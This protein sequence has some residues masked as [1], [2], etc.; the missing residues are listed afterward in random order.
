MR[1]G[2]FGAQSWSRSISSFS[3]RNYTKFTKILKKN[4]VL[5][6]TA[7]VNPN[8]TYLRGIL[9]EN[10]EKCWSNHFAIITLAVFINFKCRTLPLMIGWDGISRLRIC[11]FRAQRRSLACALVPIQILQNLWKRFSDPPNLK[12]ICAII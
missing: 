10:D 5:W 6:S 1:F 4:Q 8:L 3:A 7:K 9:F 11:L 2:L 12:I